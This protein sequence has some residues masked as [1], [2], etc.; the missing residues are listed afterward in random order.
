MTGPVE[1]CLSLLD[2]PRQTGP[3]RWTA[4]CPAH[5]DTKPSLTITRGKDGRLLLR[6]HAGCS[7]EAILAAVGMKPS[8]AF[9]DGAPANEPVRR[10]KPSRRRSFADRESLIRHLEK[11]VAGQLCGEW[12]YQSGDGE[13]L[14]HVARFDD[15][16]GGG[17][18]YRPFYCRD[19]RWHLG[20]PPGPLPLY[21][22]PEV[23]DASEVWVCEGEKCV[24]VFRELGLIATTNAHGALS[25]EKTDWQPL[26]GKLI[27]IC[28][29]N[30]PAGDQH[31]QSLQQALRELVPTP[32]LRVVRLPLLNKGDD[33]EQFVQVR[34]EA[35]ASAS[36]IAGELTRLA[37]G[38]TPT[39]LTSELVVVRLSDVEPTRQPYLWPGRIPA[40]ACSLIGGR[41]GST[42]NM[43][44][45]DTIARVTNGDAWPDDAPCA[46]GGPRS[47][48]LLEAEEH[49][50]SS[51]V[52]RLIAAGA[53]MSRVHYIKGAPVESQ[54]R[55]RLISI[56][57]D[58]DAIE[59]LARQ[60]GDVAL[61]VVSPITSYLGEVEQNS[62]EQV[63][64][65]I[66]H[67]LKTMAEELGCAVVI[68]KHPNKEWRNTD[69]LERIGGSAAWTE[70]MRCVV[71]IGVDPDEAEGETNP[72]RCAHWVK[73][74][75]GPKPRP[76]SWKVRLVQ[77]VPT[78]G[79][80]EDPVTFS[81]SEMLAG[82]RPSKERKTKRE[83]A[84]EWIENTLELGP[85]LASELNDLALKAVAAD[86]R[87]SMDAFE[88]ARID[89]RDA[90]RLCYERKPEVN[91]PEWWY[92]LT[93]GPPPSWF[94]GTEEV[95]SSADSSR[96]RV[97]PPT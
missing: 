47:V 4:K 52:P 23:A 76:L 96:A 57:R 7:F 91:P 17:K 28:P 90:D 55:T 71:F 68:L 67:P 8:E 9:P 18:E 21:G 6:C 87:F 5:D 84:A 60:L 20:D 27:N 79:F 72:R 64:N 25:V 41:Q 12:V 33:I 78:I 89:L 92:W 10:P 94:N 56:Q 62:N 74:S 59:R 49:L 14:L 13:E 32:T 19:G 58:A 70:A 35:G 44:A 97:G 2:A 63:R 54:D 69:P 36:D 50:E 31:C 37:E 1:R 53:D 66:I 82:R 3:D 11:Q 81:A 46:T 15:C 40:A 29:D 22:L 75:L 16:R 48:V 95:A 45:Y 65:E 26:A 38:A 80:L 86:R 85:R 73:F 30:D 83:L 34:Q 39:S 88:R 24:E 42:K 93:S 77:G 43:F 51:I 61:V